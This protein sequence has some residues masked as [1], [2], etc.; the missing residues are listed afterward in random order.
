MLDG[1]APPTMLRALRA[2]RVLL[3][4]AHPTRV[5]VAASTDA[6]TILPA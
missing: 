3:S 4:D 2:Q 5:A 6:A 1:R